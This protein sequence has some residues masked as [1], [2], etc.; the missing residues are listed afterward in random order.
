VKASLDSFLNTGNQFLNRICYR[1]WGR[2][3]Y[4]SVDE[5]GGIFPRV[6]KLVSDVL[7]MSPIDITYIYREREKLRKVQSKGFMVLAVGI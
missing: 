7:G 4:K 6:K 3:C 1:N 2:L 5:Y